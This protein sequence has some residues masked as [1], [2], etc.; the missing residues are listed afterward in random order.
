MSVEIVNTLNG[1]VTAVFVFFGIAFNI[2]TIYVLMRPVKHHLRN[3][4]RHGFLI[5]TGLLLSRAVSIKPPSSLSRPIIH[6]YLLWL[7]VSDTAL[8]L[9]G[10]L[11]YCLP[12][13][14]ISSLGFYAKF[15]PAFYLISNASLTASVWLMCVLMFERYRAFCKPL[16][17]S[18]MSAAKVHK[19]LAFVVVLSIIFS[20]PRFFEVVVLEYDDGFVDVV[21][22]DLGKNHIY[23]FYYRIIGGLVFYSLLPYIVLFA[24]SAKISLVLRTAAKQRQIMSSSMNHKTKAISDSELI[25]LAVMAKFLLSRLMPTALDVAEHIV[26]SEI[27]VL[28]SVATLIVAISNLLVVI[29]SGIN[30]FIYF[31]FSKTF[32]HSACLCCKNLPFFSCKTARNFNDGEATNT[33]VP[34]FNKPDNFLTSL[35]LFNEAS[36][37]SKKN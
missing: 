33:S 36:D 1:P 19:I 28:S 26:T 9:S 3:V 11:M 10:F 31:M 6:T 22:S 32:R 35:L 17:T 34:Q 13:F 5:Q 7:S 18:G 29:S 16:I 24:L 2:E 15:F 14:F 21:Q 12:S 30:F 25:L 37:I 8:L 23:L 4:N 27:F 20:L